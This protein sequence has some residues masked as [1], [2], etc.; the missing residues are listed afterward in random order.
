M[1]IRALDKVGYTPDMLASEL[2]GMCQE[3]KVQRVYV[4]V[5]LPD[6]G[7]DAFWSKPLEPTGRAGSDVII[8]GVVL[9][10]MG[11]NLIQQ[12]ED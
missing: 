10:Q 1:K 3:G 8:A 9:Q 4:V 11:I 12:S 5:D 6:G 2:L 7:V